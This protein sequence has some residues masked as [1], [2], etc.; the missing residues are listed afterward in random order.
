MITI[1]IRLTQPYS[2]Y[3]GQLHRT[4][5]ARIQALKLGNFAVIV[6]SATVHSF[7]K[8]LMIRACRGMG[9]RI[10]VIPDGEAAKT[11]AVLFKVLEA[12]SRED[13]LGRKCFLVCWGGGTVGDVGGLAAAL[14]KRGI[15]YVQVPTT[16]L[17]QI[18]ASIGGKTA[19][20]MP[21]AKNSVGTIHQPRAVFVDPAFLNTLPLARFK[22]GISE[23]IKYGIIRDKALFYFLKNN[24]EK[25]LARSPAHLLE[26]ISRCAAI[27]AAI[28][29][30]D[31]DEK[32]GI[33][34]VLNFG[35]TL[36][37]AL[38]ADAHYKKIT[39]GEAVSL[40]MRYAGYLSL[41]LGKCSSKEV[42][43]VREILDLFKLPL[44]VRFSPDSLL[45][46]LR[47]DKKFISGNIRMVA[48]IRIGTVRVIEPIPLSIVKKALKILTPIN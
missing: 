37:H 34:T 40:G 15:A 5:R 26:L 3:I 28:V 18:D 29:E 24:H 14:Y 30:R 19:I 2:I 6:T 23:A 11:K 8:S 17:A 1:K 12:L 47:H 38:E 13:A 21:D 4:L 7:Y 33:R 43:E 31:P 42:E 27:K 36:A 45:E 10:V 48:L 20:D 41:L 9:Y 22:E 16:L 39:H 44:T 46:T 25:I 35:H 32:R